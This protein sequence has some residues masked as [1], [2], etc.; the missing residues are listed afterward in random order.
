MNYC[1]E[2]RL[3][4]LAPT[5]AAR[6]T[7]LAESFPM[8]VVCQWIGN[9]QAIAAKHYLQVT[10]DHYSQA[11]EQLLNEILRQLPKGAQKPAQKAPQYIGI[12]R[13]APE[14]DN[15]LSLDVSV[16][17]N[18]DVAIIPPRGFEPLSPP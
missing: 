15:Q 8:H 1:A 14:P 17:S 3:L 12:E 5:S 4:T 9:T 18:L 7:E 10:D 11:T 2:D 6:E 16:F 13:Q